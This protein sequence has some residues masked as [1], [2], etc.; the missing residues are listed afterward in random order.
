MKKWKI[1][2]P[3]RSAA[4]GRPV[5]LDI[6][7]QDPLCFWFVDSRTGR[8]H[9]AQTQNEPEGEPEA[10]QPNSYVDAPT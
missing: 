2:A 3:A 4:I 10:F 9:Y 1:R 5:Q 7:D 6:F 8:R